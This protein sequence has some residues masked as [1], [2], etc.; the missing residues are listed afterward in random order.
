[1]F[2]IINIMNRPILPSMMLSI[3]YPYLISIYI[4]FILLPI[5]AYG[6]YDRAL[7]LALKNYLNM[8]QR[9]K[10]RKIKIIYLGQVLEK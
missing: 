5:S 8:M 6:Q 9:W 7:H 2:N 1:M 10:S 4:D 3:Q